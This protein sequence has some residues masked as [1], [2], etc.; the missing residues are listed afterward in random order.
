MQCAGVK[1]KFCGG[2]GFAASMAMRR[3][4]VLDT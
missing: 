2:T 4:V 1:G 3:V